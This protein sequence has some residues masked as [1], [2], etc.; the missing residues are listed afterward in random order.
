LVERYSI[1][2]ENDHFGFEPL[3]NYASKISDAKYDKVDVRDVAQ[4]QAHL[5]INQRNDVEH[6]G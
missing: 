6:L 2:I 4:E 3:D 1:E 5:T